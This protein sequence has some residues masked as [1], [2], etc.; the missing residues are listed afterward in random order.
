MRRAIPILAAAAALTAGGCTTS[1]CDPAVVN[2][3]WETF[4][5]SSGRPFNCSDPGSGVASVQVFV[6]GQ[7]QFLSGSGAP[8]P[9]PCVPF[10]NGTEGVGLVDFAPGTYTFDVQAYDLN[11]RLR[12]EDQQTLS[13]PGNACGQ[14]FTVDTVPAATTGTLTMSVTFGRRASCAPDVDN[15]FI[16]LVDGLGQPVPN[17][18]SVFVPCVDV[19]GAAPAFQIP[20]LDFG[21]TYTFRTLAGTQ[22][23]AT[24][25]PTNQRTIYQLCGAPV[26]FNGLTQSFTVDVPVA[27]AGQQCP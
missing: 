11:G 25:P 10:S 9:I 27:V 20:D 4:T 15:F 22:N 3:Y 5:D 16:E 14:A 7:A 19:A 24:A 1:H 6:N 26:A 8:Q 17:A 18:A 21:Q 13:I 12:Y 2:V 23:D